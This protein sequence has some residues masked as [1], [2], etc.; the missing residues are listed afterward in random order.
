MSRSITAFVVGMILTGVAALFLVLTFGDSGASRPAAAALALSSS[1]SAE[2]DDQHEPANLNGE[3]PTPPP[4]NRWAIASGPCPL[5]FPGNR[6]SEGAG[7]AIGPVEVTKGARFTA[8]VP[9]SC[10]NT[11]INVWARGA[12]QVAPDL[13]IY[14]LEPTDKSGSTTARL[15]KEVIF[16]AP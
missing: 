14:R 15:Q 6:P 7:W 10:D 12:W 9:T 4:V 2:I 8:Y 5:V 16:G 13:V 11:T 3:V 1:G